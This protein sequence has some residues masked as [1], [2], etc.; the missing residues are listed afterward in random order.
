MLLLCGGGGVFSLSNC[1]VLYYR[2]QV[3]RDQFVEKLADMWLDPVGNQLL[4]WVVKS[5]AHDE[6]E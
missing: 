2:M 5:V 6:V 1:F 3:W 4:D